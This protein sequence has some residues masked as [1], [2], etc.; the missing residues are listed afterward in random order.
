VIVTTS[1]VIRRCAIATIR[2]NEHDSV[3]LRRPER[4]GNRRA[5]AREFPD[6]EIL[7][8]NLASS[9]PAHSRTPTMRIGDVSSTSTC[10]AACGCTPLPAAMRRANWGASF[11]SRAKA[12]CRSREMI[13]YGHQEAQL[14]FA[15]LARP[16]PHRYH[17]QFR[18]AGPTKS[19]GVTQFVDTLSKSTAR[20][21]RRF[22]PS[23]SGRAPDFADQALRHPEE[24][25]SLIVY[26]ASP[27]ARPHGARCAWT[28]APSERLLVLRGG[29]GIKPPAGGL[30]REHPSRRT[31]VGRPFARIP[32]QGAQVS[33]YGA[34]HLFT[35]AGGILTRSSWPRG[36]DAKAPL[37]GRPLFSR[38]ATPHC[39]N[40]D[41]ILT[42]TGR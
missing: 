26:L 29:I 16:W 14:G 37:L 28:E 36:S 42:S 3:G 40:K 24:V 15:R 25:A 38:S 18:A 2:S 30:L 5:L 10:S 23:S 20:A 11:S 22:R 12:V 33:R 8:N 31:R 7:I 13:H 32:P 35:L 17:R 21:S 39:F 1:A 34:P 41:A 4:C 27:L 9:S 6:V 19:R